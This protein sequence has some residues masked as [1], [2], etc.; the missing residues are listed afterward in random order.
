M[1]CSVFSAVTAALFATSSLALPQNNGE[2]SSSS[3][4]CNNSPKLCNRQYNQITHLGAHNS[5]FLTSQSSGISL[6][7]NQNKNATLALDAGLRLLQAQVHKS[8]D[9]LHLCHTECSILDAGLLQDWL[10]SIAFWMDNNPNEVVTI[11]LVNSDKNPASEYGS[12]FE[13]AGLAKYGYK[14]QTTGAT[15]NWPTLQNMIDQKTRLVSFLTNADYDQAVPYLLPEFEYVFETPF[16]VTQING[17]NCTLD[18]PSRLDTAQAALSSN[19]LSLVNHFKYQVIFGDIMSP[20]TDNITTVNNPGTSSPGNLG[21]HLQTC[22]KQW[23]SRPNFVL[24]DFWDQENPIAAADSLNGLK[25]S[26]IEGRVSVE[27]IDGKSS[28]ASG[29]SRA[30]LALLAVIAVAVAM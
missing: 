4:A 19:Y 17:F 18:R 5:A 25:A 23:G 16:E 21:T 2:S 27:E 29:L 28:D 8:E 9:G 20:D 12:A 1:R 22:N 14:P 3:K 10:T 6:A 24:L 26:D 11:L 15:G 13:A 30:R 7:G